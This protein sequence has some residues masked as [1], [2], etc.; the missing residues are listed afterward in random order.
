MAVDGA[1]RG[2]HS[3]VDQATITGES[4]PVEKSAGATVYAGTINQA[5]ALEI[6]A[7][8][9]GRDTSFGKSIETV[10]R[11]EGSRAPVQKTADRYAGYLVYFAL[12]CAGLTFAITRD[13]RA[14]ISVIIVAGACG[15][16]AGT[17]LAVL[18]AIGRSARTGAIIKGGRYRGA[19][20]R[21]HR[22]LRQ[23]GH[24]H[25]GDPGGTRRSPGGRRTRGG[26]A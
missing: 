15:I 19:V 2:G 14:T 11:A 9:L 26:G 23:D 13:P 8:R 3:F 12:A 25:R 10:E 6:L 18:G 7:Q 4:T 17:P 16:A 1:V 21:G 24:G 5:G 20:G 22:R